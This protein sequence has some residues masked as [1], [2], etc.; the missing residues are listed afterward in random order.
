MQIEDAECRI[1]SRLPFHLELITFVGKLEHVK[2][3]N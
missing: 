2:A 1:D 3:L